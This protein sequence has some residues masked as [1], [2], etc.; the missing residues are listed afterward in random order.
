VADTH[1]TE[2]STE[3]PIDRPEVETYSYPWATVASCSDVGLQRSQNDDRV[4]VKPWPDAEALLLVVADGL[5]GSQSGGLAAEIACETF[6]TLV[7]QPLPP[8]PKERY[9]ALAERCYAADQEVLDQGGQSFQTLG[10]G[11]TVVSAIVTPQD[12]VYLH[13]GDSRLYQLREGQVLR[14]SRDHSIVELLLESGRITEADIPTHPMRSVVNSC[15]GGKRSTEHFSIDPKWDENNPPIYPLI[16][17]D[18]LLLS[19]DGFHG[20][21]PD[22]TFGQT[23]LDPEPMQFLRKIGHMALENGGRDNLSAIALYLPAYSPITSP[24]TSHEASSEV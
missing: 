6:A 3:T 4:L 9:E 19:T 18:W 22:I 12:Y 13:A 15:L 23:S 11:C 7:E 10:M 5:G 24:E 20:Y 2:T 16:A 17:Q 8:T 1:P 21:L 14:R